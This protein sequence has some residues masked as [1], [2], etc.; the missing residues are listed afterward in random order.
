M[1]SADGSADL[2]LISRALSMSERIS[3]LPELVECPDDVGSEVEARVEAWARQVSPGGQQARFRERLA[4]LNLDR[5]GAARVASAFRLPESFHRPD[6]FEIAEQVREQL[7]REPEPQSVEVA[8]GEYWQGW[9]SVARARLEARLGE[10]GSELPEQVL[11]QLERNLVRELAALGAS[12]LMSA[13]DEH[14]LPW[15]LGPDYLMARL[16]PTAPNRL[17]RSFVQQLRTT[18]LVPNRWPSLIRLCATRLSCWVDAASELSHRIEVDRK[19]LGALVGRELGPVLA[20]D[21]VSDSHNAGRRVWLVSFGHEIKLVYKPRGVGPELAFHDVLEWTNE[22]LP[23]GPRLETHWTLDRGSYGWTEYVA[24]MPCSQSEAGDYYERAGMLLALAYVLAGSDCHEENVIAHGVCPVLVDLETFAGPQLLPPQQ[25][26]P[27]YAEAIERIETE[28]VLSIGMLPGWTWSR[29]GRADISG[30]GGEGKIWYFRFAQLNTDLMRLVR[31]EERVSRLCANQPRLASGAAIQADLHVDAILRGFERVYTLVQE[32]LDDFARPDGPL[33]RLR[34]GRCRVVFRDTRLYSQILGASLKPRAMED[35]FARSVSLE[36]LA[37]DF[38]GL[39][40]TPDWVAGLLGAEQAALLRGDI[41][42]FLVGRTDGVLAVGNPELE[43]ELRIGTMHAEGTGMRRLESRLRRLGPADLRFQRRCIESAFIGH[44]IRAEAA[45]IRSAHPAPE[46]DFAPRLEDAALGMARA[47]RECSVMGPRG[48]RFW[49]GLEPETSDLVTS[50]VGVL[51][52]C[53]YSGQAGIA[54]SLAAAFA[55]SRDPQFASAALAAL[56]PVRE[57][58]LG[59]RAS[60]ALGAF[61][62]LSGVI[63]ALWHSARLL[64]EPA[65]VDDARELLRRF[66]HE[67]VARDRLFDVTSGSAGSILALRCLEPVDRRAVR[68]IVDACARHLVQHAQRV[69]GGVGWA[70]CIEP[71]PLCGMAHGNSGIACALM[72]AFRITGDRAFRDV[73]LAATGY[74]RARRSETTDGAWPDLRKRATHVAGWCHGPPGIALARCAMLEI[75]DDPELRADLELART[76]MLGR[77]ADE[78]RAHLCC[79]QTGIDDVL[80]ELGLRFREPDL[81]ELARARA[82]NRIR[83]LGD[84]PSAWMHPGLG[85]DTIPTIPGMMKGW[86]GITWTLLR[87]SDPGGGMPCVL[88]LQP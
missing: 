2:E 43:Q 42:L 5:A 55:R 24:P 28:S 59:D 72:E 68:D 1:G 56:A 78:P 4:W 86:S 47:V 76:L 79:G 37:D 88:G 62:G 69:E 11:T 58:V 26:T 38:L 48:G 46:G 9:G 40:P 44:A 51:G 30:L 13:F 45:E 57:L 12:C 53:L 7:A 15:Q 33:E 17:Y 8:F 3:L 31:G 73:A 29:F 70:N 52:P 41:P 25:G 77:S 36:G 65:L 80:L 39:D 66:D 84:Q 63:Y 83:S 61:D 6:W 32:H 22:R 34:N 82:S 64:G 81:I 75:E 67:S 74:E 49:L 50:R 27:E 20:L 19:A 14:R 85:R 60:M 87:L 23:D 21:G 54:L 35:G 71:K 18:R 10:V 16:S